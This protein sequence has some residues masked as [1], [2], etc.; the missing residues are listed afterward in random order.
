MPWK[1]LPARLAEAAA[2]RLIA[3]L[4]ADQLETLWRWSRPISTPAATDPGGDGEEA[5]P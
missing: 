1:E 5:G 3:A 2:A 4:R